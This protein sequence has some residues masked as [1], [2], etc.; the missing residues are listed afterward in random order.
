MDPALFYEDDMHNVAA[1]MRRE[2]AAAGV[3]MKKTGRGDGG[4]SIL[5]YDNELNSDGDYDTY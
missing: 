4:G 3:S 5:T 1:H 2:N